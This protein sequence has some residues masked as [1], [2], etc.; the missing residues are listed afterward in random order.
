MEK[1]NDIIKKLGNSSKF[2]ERY[3]K[4]RQEILNNDQVRLFIKEHENELTRSMIH[5][6]LMV[7]RDY[8][9][10][11][12]NCRDCST[13]ENCQNLMK[14]YQPKLKIGRNA[15]DIVYEKCPLL[16]MEEKKRQSE[17][18]I[19]SMFVPKDIMDA[20]LETLDY[21]DPGRLDAI[22]R[23]AEF[24]VNYDPEKRMKGLYFYGSFGVGKSYIMGA[25]A[26]GL[27]KKN[28]P[29]MIVYFP[30]LLRELKSSI[31]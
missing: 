2:Q 30:E 19:Q 20:T 10:Q 15:I 21:E 28:V 25:I 4:M 13:L 8:A 24:V 5:K 23:A 14:G 27:A 7:L 6:S 9:M 29:S 12:Q 3:E 16:L 17:R 31:A 22:G 1:I 26:N 11:T 18:L